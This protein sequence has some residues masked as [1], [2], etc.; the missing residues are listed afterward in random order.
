MAAFALHA[1]PTAKFDDAYFHSR[2]KMS[3]KNNC[4][5]LSACTYPQTRALVIIAL[6]TLS[7]HPPVFALSTLPIFPFN[8]YMHSDECDKK[9]QI[10]DLTGCY[11]AYPPLYLPTD[12]RY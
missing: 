9:F 2:R 7:T 4:I 8:K 1:I 12:Y 6:A 3:Q 11:I 10:M 5:D